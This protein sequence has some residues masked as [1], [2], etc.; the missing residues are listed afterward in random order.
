VV[1]GSWLGDMGQAI[2]PTSPA[3]QALRLQLL[4]LLPPR[5]PLLPLRSSIT[6]LASVTRRQDFPLT[7]LGLNVFFQRAAMKAFTSLQI[8]GLF[9]NAPSGSRSSLRDRF[10]PTHLPRFRTSCA[11]PTLPPLLA[12]ERPFHPAASSSVS[13]QQDSG[14]GIFNKLCSPDRYSFVYNHLCFHGSFVRF[15]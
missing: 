15:V 4:R 8:W 14:S 13:E 11:R 7:H 12:L 6:R 1:A 9:P 5:L 2:Y 10:L 3:D